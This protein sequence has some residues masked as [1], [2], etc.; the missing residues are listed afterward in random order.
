MVAK[1]LHTVATYLQRDSI[2]LATSAMYMQNHCH[3]S[4]YYLMY[5]YLEQTV[6]QTIATFSAHLNSAFLLNDALSITVSLHN[7][8]QAFV[9][10]NRV[11]H[12]SALIS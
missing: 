8:M 3:S 9:S 11:L 6:L 5:S 7:S 1:Y 2:H 10:C 4:T 12:T